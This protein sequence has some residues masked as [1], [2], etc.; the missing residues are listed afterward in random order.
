LEPQQDN[1]D[2][3]QGL[4]LTFVKVLIESTG[5]EL[6]VPVKFVD[7]YNEACRV[8]GDNRNKEESNLELRQL[9]RDELLNNGYI[10][11]DSK[12]I[13]SIYLTQ[14]TIDEYSDY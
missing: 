7:I 9:V 14:K 10:F 4:T 5:K 12:D 8:R 11:A 3:I 13:D 2:K 1:S 6:K